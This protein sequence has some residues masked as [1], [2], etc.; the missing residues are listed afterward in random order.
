M[1]FGID[2]HGVITSNPTFFK[3][4]NALLLQNHHIVT[5]LSGGHFKD[6]QSYLTQYNIPFSNI[7]SLLDMFQKRNMVTF[8]PDGSFFVADNL[9]NSAKAKYCLEQHIDIHI[10]DSI[11]YGTYFQTPFCLYTSNPQQC[12]LLKNNL[13]I[14]FSQSPEKVLADIQT[15]LKNQ[16]NIA[17][18]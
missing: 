15:V 10:D 4:F 7:F 12:T 14:N 8:Y 5:V 18:V 1:K 16:F 11:L 9:W 3:K 13:S 6:V 17:D 2:Y